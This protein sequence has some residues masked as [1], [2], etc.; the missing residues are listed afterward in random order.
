MSRRAAIGW[1]GVGA[2][3][4]AAV[5][6]GLAPMRNAAEIVEGK[7]PSVDGPTTTAS[8]SR[9]GEVRLERAEQQRVGLSVAPAIT[10]TAPA[11]THGFARGLDGG[12]LAA[13]DAEIVTARAAAGASRAEAARLAELFAQD[14][15]ASAK[16]VEAARAQSAADAARVGLAER[17][18]G[19]EYGPGLARLGPGARHALIADIAAGRAALVRIDVP[20]ANL[21]ALSRMRI[22]GSAVAVL[23]PA[24]AA[25]ARLQSAGLLAILRGP[26]AASVTNGR[27]L[28]V[29]VERGSA[30]SGVAVPRDAVL[31]WRGGL[32]VYR[33]E[34]PESFERVELVDARPIGGGW[35][36][37]S[38]L[39][40][41][42][43]VVTGGA[44]TL[45][46]ID[47]NGGSAAESD[48]D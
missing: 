7:R 20:G 34:G 29:K 41:G 12:A 32:W 39:T 33:Q 18:I 21:D 15:S 42:N 5:L 28:D 35:F 17:R 48:G 46:A 1:A 47:R 10:T 19:L 23:G 22:D 16:S 24:A 38:G 37:R 45:L 13:I 6:L 30:E 3:I 36:V 40:A 8:S 2:G 27:I 44:E 4:S 26:I 9:D 31:R 25:D 14:Q 43:R 11:I